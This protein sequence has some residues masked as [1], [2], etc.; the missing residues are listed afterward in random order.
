MPRD[1]NASSEKPKEANTPDEIPDHV[2]HAAG[3]LLLRMRRL[4]KRP[5]QNGGFKPKQHF[6]RK[7]YRKLSPKSQ[8][9]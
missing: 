8:L 5:K 1:G 7:K 9:E 3:V 4:P 2:V 6:F